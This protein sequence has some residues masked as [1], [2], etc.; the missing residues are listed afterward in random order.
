MAEGSYEVLFYRS[1]RGEC[2]TEEFLNGLPA[3]VR[4]KVL[5]WIKAL[6]THGPNL[7]RPY[8]DVVRGKIRE[9]RIV[10]STN[11]YRLLYF[12]A[13]KQIVI[14]HGFVKKTDPVPVGEL[15]RAERLMHEWLS[16]T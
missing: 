16:R 11:Q 3:K 14:T 7:P 2:F 13:G 9:L 8:A 1:P 15:D 12:F 10:F 5:R 4:G 6:E